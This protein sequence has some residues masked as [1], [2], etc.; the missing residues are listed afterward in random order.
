MEVMQKLLVSQQK[1]QVLH[2]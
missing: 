2:I 1:L